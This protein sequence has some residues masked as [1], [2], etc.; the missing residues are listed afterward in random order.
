MRNILA[1]AALAGVLILASNGWLLGAANASAPSILEPPAG[2]LLG[3][4]YGAGSLAQ[5]AAKLGR[6]PP[7]HLTY[8]AWTDDWT[9]AVTKADLSVGRIPLVN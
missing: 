4:Y 1:S 7:V 5:T 6:T 8:Y 3:L 9:G 2:A